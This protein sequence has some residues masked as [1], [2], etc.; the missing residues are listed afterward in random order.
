MDE[1]QI[2]E[3]K[4]IQFFSDYGITKREYQNFK[5]KTKSPYPH[6]I[7]WGL[8]NQIALRLMKEKDLQELKMLYY[9]MAL[10]LNEEGKNPFELLKQSRRME[11][12]E[13]KQNGIDKVMVCYGGNGCPTC[14]KLND[15]IFTVDE[16][17]KTMPLPNKNCSFILDKGRFPFCRC[18]WTCE[19]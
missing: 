11:L 10:F 15:K 6:D 14:E 5:S 16:T 18:L 13:L 12:Y 4:W 3:E 17:L 1:E 2:F 7:V 19:I 8:F 9:S